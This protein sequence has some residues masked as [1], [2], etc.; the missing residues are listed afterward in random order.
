[1]IYEMDMADTP[2]TDR[3]TDREVTKLISL[4]KV[5]IGPA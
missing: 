1:M 3:Q 4:A 5:V 2:Q